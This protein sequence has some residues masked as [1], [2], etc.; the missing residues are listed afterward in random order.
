MW[1]AKIMGANR[2]RLSQ[3]ATT[4]SFE[5]V[6]VM[7]ATKRRDAAIK[8]MVASIAKHDFSSARQYSY[9]ETRLKNLIRDL[10]NEERPVTSPVTTGPGL[11]KTA[12]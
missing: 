4:S 1:F 7:E 2:K 11:G 3:E 6:T 10:A 8:N 12:P 9:E 5:P